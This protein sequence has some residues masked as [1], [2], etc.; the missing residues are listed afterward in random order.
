V[1]ND[2]A[3]IETAGSGEQTPEGKSLVSTLEVT[4]AITEIRAAL[5][6][7]QRRIGVI[8]A[9][10]D[11]RR[12]GSDEGLDDARS[13][14]DL[15]QLLLGARQA[16]A[17]RMAEIESEREEILAFAQHMAQT[18]VS[19]AEERARTIELEAF[20]A[21]FAGPSTLSTTTTPVDPT[22]VVS[23]IDPEKKLDAERGSAPLTPRA[24][25]RTEARSARAAALLEALTSFT[26]ANASLAEDVASMAHH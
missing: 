7:L 26:K 6:T 16:A 23:K 10:S 8:A 5:E 1:I 15:G 2:V 11:G 25:P 20:R 19:T 24:E 9:W 3:P 22:L 14:R 21:R 12:G 17:E 4:A 18:I 13:T